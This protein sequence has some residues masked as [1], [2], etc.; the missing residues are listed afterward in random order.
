M[1]GLKLCKRKFSDHGDYSYLGVATKSHFG[2]SV[3]C[4]E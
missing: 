2:V 4:T 3:L 1:T